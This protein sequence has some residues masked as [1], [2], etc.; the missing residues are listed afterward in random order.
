MRGTRTEEWIWEGAEAS[1][2]LCL[3]T[4]T[5]STCSST[6]AGTTLSTLSP[7]SLPPQPL[8]NA[9]CLLSLSAPEYWH[10]GFCSCI[11]TR[12]T[13]PL[14][15]PSFPTLWF[16]FC[17]TLSPDF[18]A[19]MYRNPWISNYLTHVKFCSQGKSSDLG[20]CSSGQSWDLMSALG[21]VTLVVKLGIRAQRS[22]QATNRRLCF[23]LLAVLLC[24]QLSLHCSGSLQ[25][26]YAAEITDSITVQG[27]VLGEKLFLGSTAAWTQI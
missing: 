18:V 8:S 25:G 22:L 13:V 20:L 9:T 17:L 19:K 12:A 7:P 6:A 27:A 11:T 2:L 1:P 14:A 4:S 24:R 16:L 5:T 23:S 10:T 15:L 21:Q 3:P 26:H